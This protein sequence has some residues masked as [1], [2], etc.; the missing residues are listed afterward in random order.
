MSI[1]KG[2]FLNGEIKAIFFDI[3]G[4]LVEK[5]R[6]AERDLQV[7]KE[8]V[9]LLHLD[10]PPA[11]LLTKINH[12]LQ[13]YKTT[14]D[15]TLNEM[16]VEEKW[17]QFLL[18]DLD[19]ELVRKNALKLQQLW[20]VSKGNARLKS[21]V[22]PVLTEIDQRGYLLGTISHSTPMYLD[23]PG[24]AELLKVRIH[25][26]VFGKRKPHPSLFVDA[27]RRCGLNPADCAYVGDHSW[28]DVV[29]PREAGYGRVILM[30]DSAGAAL[31]ENRLM[32]PDLVI[33]DLED[34]LE[35]F[36]RRLTLA[37]KEST[38][39][40]T[41]WLYDA[42]LST[43]WWNQDTQTA[44]EFF[45]SGRALGFARF[46]LNHQIPPEAMQHIDT[47]RFSIG[48]LHDPCPAHTHARVLEQTDIQITSLDEN[49]RRQGVDVVKGTIDEACRMGCRLVVI[50]PGRIICDHS[51][52][53]QLRA[54]YR[55][56][57]KGTPDYEELRQKTIADRASRSTPHLE[58]CLESLREI[59][60]FASGTGLMLGLEN[61]FH[62]YELPVFDEM[63]AMLNEFRQP[64]VGWQFDIGHLQVH[65]QLGLLNMK[66][67]L[68]QFNQ[69][70][71][72][73]HL[74]DVI[75]IK[76]HQVPGTGEVDFA[77]I[78][79]YLPTDCYHTLEVDKVHNREAVDRG[80]RY[81]EKSGC[82]KR[83]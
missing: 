56:G 37:G 36:P 11:E 52:D 30:N 41:E 29:G 55:A 33:H 53:D 80:I 22:L 82:I 8:M 42:A 4:T 48:S 59:I 66:D 60:A 28:R 12:G 38:S 57:S 50:H 3:G 27:A 9:T 32:K 62:F 2:T 6:Y 76:D 71:V 67:W 13:V 47:N 72:G 25:T 69:R 39:T 7:I 40:G 68:H 63:Q 15:Q 35:V 18:P 58:K 17:T 43:M 46:E 21:T 73:L 74:H 23:E 79:K 24:I 49:R 70:I 51:M 64:W 5:T 61:R 54:M 77:M 45:T 78:A 10:C 16:S 44:N 31:S 81:L 19:R 83:I 34:L 20:R 26:P 65:D 14:C 1:R 75:G